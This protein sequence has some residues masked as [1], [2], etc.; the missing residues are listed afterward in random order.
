[1]TLDIDVLNNDNSNISA[2]YSKKYLGFVS[3]FLRV[4]VMAAQKALEPAKYNLTLL[5]RSSTQEMTDDVNED[6]ERF[7]ELSQIMQGGLAEDIISSIDFPKLQ[8][9]TLLLVSF[10]AGKQEVSYEDF[11]VLQNSL[12]LWA[13]A[14]VSTS[15]PAALVKQFFDN[16]TFAPADM[17][18]KGVYY[19][20]ESQ[21]ARKMRSEFSTN[22]GIMTQ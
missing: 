20:G 13:N 7:N 17:V 1:M 10:I 9:R 16:T 22:I 14:Y 2:M 4:F 5:R 11:V 19:P 15:D 18:V 21:M 12:P 8:E 6:T 3:K